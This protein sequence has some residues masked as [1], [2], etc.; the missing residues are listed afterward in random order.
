MDPKDNQK[1]SQKEYQSTVRVFFAPQIAA[2]FWLGIKYVLD[3]T[4]RR[5]YNP[6]HTNDQSHGDVANIHR[7]CRYPSACPKQ[8]QESK[9]A[10]RK[11]KSDTTSTTINTPTI[12]YHLPVMCVWY[13][14]VC[15]K[16]SAIVVSVWGSPPGKAG[17]LRTRKRQSE[18]VKPWRWAYLPVMSAAR[19][20]VHMELAE[21]H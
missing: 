2:M 17:E 19:E 12:A 21:I 11:K 6:S 10:K 20:G 7:F 8:Q 16:Y 15:F 4:P 9:R 5:W 18:E 3:H 14:C 1:Q 13:P